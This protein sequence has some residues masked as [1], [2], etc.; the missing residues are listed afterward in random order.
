MI[1]AYA[2]Q[3]STVKKTV[4]QVKITNPI[5]PGYYADPAIIKVKDVFYIYATI[6]PWGQDF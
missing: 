1:V 2:C 4:E 6:D 3:N 5:L